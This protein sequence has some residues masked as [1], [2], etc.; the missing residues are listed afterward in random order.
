MEIKKS[1]Q[2]FVVYFVSI[3]GLFG[4]IVPIV[5]AQEALSIKIAPAITERDIN[6][7]DQIEINL[8]ATN[9]N[10][11]GQF[12]SVKKYGIIGNDDNGKPIFAKNSDEEQTTAAPWITVVHDQFSLKPFESKIIPIKIHVPAD[13]FPGSYFAGVA[14]E[15]GASQERKENNVA[16]VEFQAISLLSLRIHGE[17]KEGLQ[18]REFKTDKMIYNQPKVLFSI[19]TKNTGTVLLRPRGPLEIWDMFGEKI[20]TLTMNERGGAILP[21]TERQFGTIWE[22]DKFAFGR[23]AAILSIAYGEKAQQTITRIIS[24]WVLPLKPISYVAGAALLLFGL[25]LGAIKL[26]IKRKLRTAG[27]IQKN[28]GR[29]ERGSSLVQ[30]ATIGM[31]LLLMTLILLVILFFFFA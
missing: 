6:A 31:I 12:F 20:T 19:K 23:Y 25:L 22:Y 15:I 18:F 17:V 1:A 28:S 27:F 29:Q 16:Y 9:L 5:I 7:A 13:A 24:F 11:T 4:I 14:V 21:N 26:Y 3:I 10:N 30:L 8:T 2:F